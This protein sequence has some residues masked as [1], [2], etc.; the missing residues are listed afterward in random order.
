M[1]PLVPGT[2]VTSLDC[3][4]RQALGLPSRLH[5]CVVR[6]SLEALRQVIT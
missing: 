1:L 5:Y 2:V 3:G 6:V 4:P